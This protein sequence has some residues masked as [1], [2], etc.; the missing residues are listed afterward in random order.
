MALTR[1]NLRP[2]FI[3]EET[4][5]WGG[6][7]CHAAQ[8]GGLLPCAA[9]AL[10]H[11]GEWG[12]RHPP[13]GSV[14][15]NREGQEDHGGSTAGLRNA[16]E[17]LRGVLVQDRPLWAN[18]IPPANQDPISWRPGSPLCGQK[19]GHFQNCWDLG[20]WAVTSSRAKKVRWSQ[21][22]TVCL[23][24]GSVEQPS[25][26]QSPVGPGVD[27]WGERREERVPERRKRAQRAGR[28][29]IPSLPVLPRAGPL[30]PTF[31][32]IPEYT[33]EGHILKPEG[34]S[35]GRGRGKASVGEGGREGEGEGGMLP[36]LSTC[37]H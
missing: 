20:E 10:E 35:Q 28:E 31:S 32:H 15:D 2:H 21:W 8:P 3:D 27:G 36:H 24:P 5:V 18:R 4:K 9:A 37:A 6:R 11:R 33:G 34:G 13:Q 1:F 17:G 19:S 25:E 30:G 26:D 23:A 7:R 22:H 16:R 29:P 12:W 14:E